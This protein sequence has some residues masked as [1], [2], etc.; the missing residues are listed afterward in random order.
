V[1]SVATK[2]SGRHQSAGETTTLAAGANCAER[3]AGRRPLLD[4]LRKPKVTLVPQRP[5]T[6]GRPQSSRI[7]FHGGTQPWDSDFSAADVILG[8]HDERVSELYAKHCSR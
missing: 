8:D 6:Y 2:G 3:R 5:R 1:L 4:S 7:P